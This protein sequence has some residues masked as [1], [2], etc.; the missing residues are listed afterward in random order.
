MDVGNGLD[1]QRRRRFE[2]VAQSELLMGSLLLRVAPHHNHAALDVRRT[3]LVGFRHRAAVVSGAGRQ[4]PAAQHGR[5]CRAEVGVHPA[6]QERIDAAR[7]HR[8][9]AQH[10]VDEPE[11]GAADA[12]HVELGDD[13]EELVRSP[14]DGED[15]HDGRQHAVGAR[16]AAAAARLLAA[17]ADVPEDE[18]VEHGDDQQRQ[19]VLD[20]ER[21]DGVQLPDVGRRPVLLTHVPADAEHRLGVDDVPR[22]DGNRERDDRRKDGDDEDENEGDGRRQ[23]LL[24]ADDDQREPVDGDHRQRQRA[25]VDDDAEHG[26]DDVAQ[27]RAECPLAGHLHT[28]RYDTVD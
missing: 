25:G 26:R 3:E 12:R 4:A 9:D 17:G 18:H 19:E 10:Q 16:L 1:G 14:G 27:R 15:E 2:L 6:V 21:H 28:I 23:T 5:E 20:D 8:H 11:V 7:A 13:G 24:D 22:E